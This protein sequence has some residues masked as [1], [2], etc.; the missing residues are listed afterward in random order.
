M[1]AVGCALAFGMGMVG[2]FG[3]A[4]SRVSSTENEFSDTCDFVGLPISMSD[5]YAI[6]L[7]A[8]LAV[9][10]LGVLS[11]PGILLF[12]PVSWVLP[13]WIIDKMYTRKI[14]RMEENLASWM[15]NFSNALDTSPAIPKALLRSS[16][17]TPGPMG[18]EIVRIC[19]RIS[20]GVSV[21][22]AFIE[23]EKRIRS[24][25]IRAA[26]QSVRYSVSAGG[27]LPRLLKKSASCIRENQRLE[28]VLRAKTADGKSQMK[29][30]AI[31]PFAVCG[32]MLA[33]DPAWFAPLL[34][35]SRG[36]VILAVSVSL[37]IASIVVTRQILKVLV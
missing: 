8:A 22:S 34:S 4:V 26:F 24:P 25:W 16:K 28:G 29:L 14:L 9:F 33:I 21:E 31:L 15:Q 6:R 35:D 3:V 12:I 11:M 1:L 2:M 27:E 10:S 19:R 18:N 23:A 7:S 32:G 5:F 17:I 36:L 37:W 13:N 30:M 20:L